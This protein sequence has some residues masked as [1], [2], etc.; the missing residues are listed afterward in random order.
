MTS[1]DIEQLR[2]LLTR[3]LTIIGDVALRESDPQAHLENLRAVSEALQAWHAQH[4]SQLPARLNHFM[5]QA[6]F[7]KALDYL[8]EMQ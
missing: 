5:T 6:S 1:Q 2:E 7:G 4:R 3:R 8:A